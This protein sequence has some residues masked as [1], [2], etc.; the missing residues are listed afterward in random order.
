MKNELNTKLSKFPEI[1][2]EPITH[3]DATPD[4][5]YP[6]RILR[7]YRDNCS[8]KWYSDTDERL[9]PIFIEMNIIQDKR[10][11]ILDK[12]IKILVQEL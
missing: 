5:D 1:N 3:I 8:M 6:L 10:A 11:Q 7:T 2:R 9:S 12:A 4:K